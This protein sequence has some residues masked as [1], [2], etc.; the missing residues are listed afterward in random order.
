MV[1]WR[2][3]DVILLKS[4]AAILYVL[5]LLLLLLLMLTMTSLL[6]LLLLLLSLLPAS[7]DH[8]RQ[9]W[10]G[11]SPRGV[12]STAGTNG[13]P[14]R[15]CCHLQERPEELQGIDNRTSS[16]QSNK[17]KYK[18]SVLC[19][20]AC[21]MSHGVFLRNISELHNPYL[22]FY[23]STENQTIQFKIGWMLRGKYQLLAAQIH[24]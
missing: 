9:V 17:S 14:Q 13:R 7:D 19:K 1:E 15:A 18:V 4:T 5:L 23:R 21:T 22:L 11:Q 6:L 10:S 20:R 3:F 8:G 16:Q 12:D 24:V 2:H